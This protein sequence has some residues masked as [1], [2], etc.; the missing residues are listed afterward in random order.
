MSPPLS[1]DLERLG[2]ALTAATTRAMAARRRRVEVTRRLAACVAVGLF[3]FAASPAHVGPAQSRAG[4]LL[5]LPDALA[6]ARSDPCDPPHGDA[7]GC[8]VD[9]PPPQVR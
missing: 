3:V 9:S 2:A 6:S 5:G 8:L 7:A 4:S 1:P